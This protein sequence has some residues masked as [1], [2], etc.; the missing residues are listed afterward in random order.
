MD[1]IFRYAV[2]H[3]GLSLFDGVLA[4]VRQTSAN[5]AA[6]L[7]PTHVGRLV[8]GFCAD[9]VV[10]DSDLTVDGV[11]RQGS[12]ITAPVGGVVPVDSAAP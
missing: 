10:S 2:R 8:P 1:H 9:L 5:P 3:S 7:G 12:W 4:A 11:L 6:A